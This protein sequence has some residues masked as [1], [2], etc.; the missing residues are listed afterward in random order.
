MMNLVLGDVALPLS[1]KEAERQANVFKA[2]GDPVRWQIL[3]LLARHREICVIDL[4][5]QFPLSQPV[6]SHHLRILFEAG[7]ISR[8]KETRKHSV[9]HYYRVC[10]ESVNEARDLLTGLLNK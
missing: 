4:V 3:N 2:M 5:R 9:Y 1:E 6:I 10:R 8:R 7:L